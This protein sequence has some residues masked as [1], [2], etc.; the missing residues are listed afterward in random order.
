[1]NDFKI[2][3]KKNSFGIKFDKSNNDDLENF[4]VYSEN[5][6]NLYVK[7][8]LD[9]KNNNK[10]I[11]SNPFFIDIEIKTNIDD[12]KI[13]VPTLINILFDENG[14]MD[15]QTFVS[16]FKE[17]QKSK[18]IFN[19]SNLKISTGDDLNK[20]FE[21]NIIFNVARNMKSNP[22]T[23]YYN[24]SLAKVIPVIIEVSYKNEDK[25]NLNNI[26]VGILTKIEQIVPLMKEVLDV[27]LL[28]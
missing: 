10:E 5:K 28:K 26:N 21:K 2:K 22:P 17:T 25:D 12:F 8:I 11:P 15:H 19:Y 24:C 20:I 23:Y 27:I 1:M 9:N 6:K 13:K 7:C 16:F 4:S 3:I 18:K 14:K